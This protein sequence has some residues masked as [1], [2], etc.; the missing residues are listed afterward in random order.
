MKNSTFRWIYVSLLFNLIFFPLAYGADYKSVSEVISHYKTQIVNLDNLDA[1]DRDYFNKSE[2]GRSPGIV[3][4]DFNG[5][6]KSDLALLTRSEL[7]FFLCTDRC[8]L[9]KRIDYGGFSGY[10][11][12]VPIKKGEVVEEFDGTEIPP[13]PSVKLKNTAVHLIF[14]GKGSMAYYWDSAIND[15]SKI[16]TNE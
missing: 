10:Q 13:V 2:Q 3:K 6:G 8:K 16:V 14:S 11:Y 5:D 15:F 9:I 1:E 7:L 4:A 12:I